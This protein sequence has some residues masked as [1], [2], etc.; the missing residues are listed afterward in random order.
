MM[1]LIYVKTGLP[2]AVGDVVNDFRGDKAEVTYFAKPHKSCSEGKVSIKEP[3]TDSM[4]HECYVSVIGAEWVDR[5]D[6]K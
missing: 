5:E 1:R 2:V 4:S 3:G 6:R